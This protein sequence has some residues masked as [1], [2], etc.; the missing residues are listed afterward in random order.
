MGLRVVYYDVM[1]KLP[2]GNTRSVATLDE[3]LAESDFVT[4]HVPATPQTNKM[5]NAEAL[6]AMK[7]GAC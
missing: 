2:L 3:L 7:P 4:L 1:T 5:I 6:A